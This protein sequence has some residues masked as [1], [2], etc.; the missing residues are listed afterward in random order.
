MRGGL[1]LIVDDDLDIRELFA[2]TFE[3]RGFEVVTAANGLEAIWVVRSMTAP[4][5]RR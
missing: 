2:E 3:D 5:A 4:P 1:V